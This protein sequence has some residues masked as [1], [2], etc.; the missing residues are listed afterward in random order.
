MR[1]QASEHA[2][3]DFDLEWEPGIREFVWYFWTV[4]PAAQETPAEVERAVHE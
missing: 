1:A 3:G 2:K 4:F